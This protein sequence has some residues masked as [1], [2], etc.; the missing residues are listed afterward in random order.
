MAGSVYMEM[1]YID[2][3]D[4]AR[5]TGLGSAMDTD[6]GTRALFKSYRY[7]EVT[8]GAA[9]FLLDLYDGSDLIDTI[10]LDAAGFRKVTGQLPKDDEAYRKIDDDY[11]ADARREKAAESVQPS[12]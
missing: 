2:S 11:W 7:L 9:K 4:Q 5:H 1:I 8:K 3:E 6:K 12:T 10:C